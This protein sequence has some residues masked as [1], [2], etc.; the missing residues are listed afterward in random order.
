MSLNFLIFKKSLH[1]VVVSIKLEMDEKSLAVT[2]MISF[3]DLY[4]VFRKTQ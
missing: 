2:M 1:K 4:S 3:T